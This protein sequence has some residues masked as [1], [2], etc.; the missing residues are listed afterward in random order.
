MILMIAPADKF[1]AAMGMAQVVLDQVMLGRPAAQSAPRAVAP[2]A[3]TPTAAPGHR[4][5]GNNLL[6]GKVQAADDLCLWTRLVR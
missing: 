5:S 6:V 4:A 1:D 3:P 2:A